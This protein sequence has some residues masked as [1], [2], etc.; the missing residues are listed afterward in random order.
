MAINSKK[1]EAKKEE[2]KEEERKMEERKKRDKA[3]QEIFGSIEIND[4][5]GK[6][7]DSFEVS[8]PDGVKLSD[9]EKI[10]RHIST[11]AEDATYASAQRAGELMKKD[12]GMTTFITTGRMGL[13]EFAA[14]TKRK[15]KGYKGECNGKTFSSVKIPFGDKTGSL[16]N[17]Q[18]EITSAWFEEEGDD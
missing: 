9:V 3:R 2:R 17:L 5:S 16:R 12:K 14:N 4:C 8:L 7:G 13:Y 18:D 15:G 11:F 10:Q 1:E 6:L